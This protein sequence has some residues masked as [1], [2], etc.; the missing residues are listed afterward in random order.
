MKI[1]FV[2]HPYPNYVPDLLLH[3][4]RKLFG[5]NVV[6]FPRKDCL[7]NGVLGLGVCPADQLFPGWF[8][9]DDD[10][11]DRYDIWKK[12]EAGF[13]DYVLCDL[14]ALPLLTANLK[15]WPSRCAVLDGEDKPQPM[16][17]GPY[18]ICRRET[19]G[20]DYS[21]PLPMALPEE[22]L[23]W[24]VQYDHLPKQ[25]SIGF[26]GSTHD[27]ERKRV[28]E[29]LAGHYSHTLFQATDVPS[30]DRP[31]PQGRLSRDDYYR[32]MQQCQMVLTLAGAGSDTFRFWENAA[33]NAL[34]LCPRFPLYIPDDFEHGVEILRFTHVDELRRQLDKHFSKDQAAKEII[35]RGRLKLVRSHLT[36]HR[37]TYLIDRVRSAFGC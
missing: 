14:R 7:Y 27:G 16:P 34:H 21:I 23:H 26:L 9:H 35:Q 17:P 22:V 4:L 18:V 15:K 19:D 24:I 20:S 6:D 2:T 10:G 25:F 12:A 30:E 29:S 11:V 5:D 8:P 33:C 36:T 32:K 31:L 13:F 3:G 28:V 1:L 37:A